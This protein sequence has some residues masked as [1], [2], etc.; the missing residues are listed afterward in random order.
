MTLTDRAAVR[1][2][3]TL[4][5]SFSSRQTVKLCIRGAG[6]KDSSGQLEMMAEGYFLFSGSG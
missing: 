1:F 5:L 3:V 2:I 4:A 6:E